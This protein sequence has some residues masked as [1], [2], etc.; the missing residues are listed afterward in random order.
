VNGGTGSGETSGAGS[1]ATENSGSG[2]GGAVG[3]PV[4]LTGYNGGSG[5]VVLSYPLQFSD[6][7]FIGAGL[8]YTK[9]VS[10][11]KTIYRFTAGTGTI[12]W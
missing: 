3:L 2:G 8:S 11:G 7:S 10:G 1:N 5:V 9:T 12:I 6:L 4:S